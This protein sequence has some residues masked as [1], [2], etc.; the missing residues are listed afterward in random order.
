MYIDTFKLKSKCIF[1]FTQFPP[2]SF[3]ALFGSAP[4]PFLGPSIHFSLVKDCHCFHATVHAFLC[5]VIS[6]IHLQYCFN[7]ETLFLSQTVPRENQPTLTRDLHPGSYLGPAPCCSCMSLSVA[8]SVWPGLFLLVYLFVRFVCSFCL[9]VLSLC[10]DCWFV[11]CFVA[12]FM[13]LLYFVC[14]VFWGVGPACI[15]LAICPFFYLAV[16]IYT[17]IY[18]IDNSHLP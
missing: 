15:C 1:F 4:V 11:C 3:W 12:L 10:F 2:L 16:I 17:Y 6:P 9:F 13:C 7:Q 8:L 14:L 5:A 18:I